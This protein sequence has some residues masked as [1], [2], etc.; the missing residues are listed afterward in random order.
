MFPLLR[1]AALVAV[2]IS[3]S[4]NLAFA[5]DIS[6]LPKYG[7]TQKTEGQLAS[8]RKFIAEIDR[9]FN[10]DRKTAAQQIAMGGWQFFRQG[11]ANDAMRRFN[12]AWMLDP[13]NGAALWGMGAIQSR[14][15]GKQVAALPLFEEAAALLPNHIDFAVDHARAIGFAGAQAKNESLIKDAL[16]RYAELY[17]KA[18]QHVPNLQNWAL[19]L[20]FLGDYAEAWKKVALAEAAPRG[21]ELDPKFVAALQSKMPR[22]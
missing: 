4:S 5:E 14:L 17:G 13:E 2:L 1:S 22:P 12:Q 8:D 9:H 6:L 18:P 21:S 7:L 19:M 16:R 20:Y 10:G 15:T 11:Q 3:L